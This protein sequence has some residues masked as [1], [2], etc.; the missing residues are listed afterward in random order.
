MPELLKT[1]IDF[2]GRMPLPAMMGASGLYSVIVAPR[3]GGGVWLV[4]KEGERE[5]PLPIRVISRRVAV[6]KDGA[7]RVP[8][9]MH[10]WKGKGVSIRP[11]RPGM[12]VAVKA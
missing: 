8:A 5:L 12:W 3:S 1:A 7:I 9:E 6:D 2:E 11:E 4:T 10:A